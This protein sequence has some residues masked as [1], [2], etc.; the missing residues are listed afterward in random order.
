MSQIKIDKKKGKFVAFVSLMTILCIA[1]LWWIFS[2]TKSADAKEKKAGGLNMQL[3]AANVQ[4]DTAKDKLSFYSVAAMDSLKRA[5]QIRMDPYRQDTT[6]AETQV[7]VNKTMPVYGGAARPVNSSTGNDQLEAKIKSIQRQLSASTYNDY[8][9]AD[10][11]SFSDQDQQQRKTVLPAPDPEMEAI[12]STLD[13]IMAIQNPKSN[14]ASTNTVNQPGYKVS[15]GQETDTTYFGKRNAQKNQRSFYNDAAGSAANPGA[16]AAIIPT[17]QTLQSG[18]VVK[19]ELRVSVSVNGV[20]LPAGTN[21]FGIASLEGERLLVHIPSIRFQN[22]LLPVS[23]N[24]YDMDGLEGI[25]VP[26]SVSREVA[27]ASADNAI[28]QSAGISGFDLSIKT[29]AAAAGI[30]AVKSL[31]SKKVKQVRVSL[32]AGYQVLLQDNKQSGQ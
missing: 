11:K 3:P 22:N 2:Q 20:A 29:Q 24:V 13:K 1:V 5:E 12:N 7:A 8:P 25:Y 4:R 23:L 6:I 21:V 30:G 19:L 14:T 10:K 26:G 17:E 31:L 28:Q 9:A 16:I 18:S 15:A 27:K 32:A